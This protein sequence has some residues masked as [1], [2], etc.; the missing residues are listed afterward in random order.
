[1]DNE[2]YRDLTHLELI[3]T[4]SDWL[5]SQGNQV[6]NEFPLPDGRVADIVY[7]TPGGAIHIVECKLLLTSTL[8]SQA[9][10]K[11]YRWCNALWMAAN[12]AEQW[13]N[14][15]YERSISLGGLRWPIGMIQASHGHVSIVADPCARELD[16][17][18]YA[19][20]RHSLPKP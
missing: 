7:T 16:P 18:L 19:R 3:A 1:M 11:Y 6:T 4:V 12:N 9:T 15:P 14:F 8:V 2:P 17:V 20:V 5:R 13:F 10:D